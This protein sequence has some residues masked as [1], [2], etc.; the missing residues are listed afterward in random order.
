MK[1]TFLP[2]LLLMFSMTA[3]VWFYPKLPDL[4]ETNT[5]YNTV[6]LSKMAAVSIMPALLFALTILTLLVAS[7]TKRNPAFS[8]TERPLFAVMNAVYVGLALVHGLILAYGMGYAVDEQIIAPLVTGI[9]FIAVGNYL[10]LVNHASSPESG[11]NPSSDPWRKG[12]RRMA[13]CFMAGG[14]LMLFSAFLPGSMLLPVF[15]VLVV[16]TSAAA[17][18]SFFLYQQKITAVK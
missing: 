14:L 7:L 4:I 15:I 17:A 8:R 18:C 12:R 16:A 6:F 10:P 2:L 13:F 9:V 11:P 1:K 5:R 3:S